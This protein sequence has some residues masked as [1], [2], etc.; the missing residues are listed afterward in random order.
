MEHAVSAEFERL[1]VEKL[2]PGGLC[3][4][5]NQ[6]GMDTPGDRRGR[7]WRPLFEMDAPAT[8]MS[9]FERDRRLLEYLDGLGIRPGATVRLKS[10]NYDDTFTLEVNGASVQLGRSAAEKIWVA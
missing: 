4:H 8:V 1:L 10:R 7:G 3:P 2:G 6:V 5:G 9:V